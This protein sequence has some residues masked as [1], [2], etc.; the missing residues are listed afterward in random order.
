MGD[1]RSGFQAVGILLLLAG[2]TAWLLWADPGPA[3]GLRHAYLIP[4]LWGGLRFGRRGGALVSV[5]AVLLYAPLVLPALEEQGVGRETLE[6]LV[7]LGW[8]GGIGPLAGGLVSR[9]RVRAERYDT[10]LT[11]QR[12]LAS[13]GP[14]DRLLGEVAEQARRSLR[15]HAVTLAVAG[16]GADPVVVRSE[17]AEAPRTTTPALSND[18][19]AAW[20][21]SRGRTLFIP[22]LGSDPRLAGDGLA[23]GRPRRALLVPLQGQAA[24]M[25]VMVV[26]RIG[27]LR[28]GERAALETLGL[29]LAL[30]IQN[31]RLAERQRRFAEELEEKVARATRRLRE[32]DRA[33]SDFVSMVSHELR[34]PLTSIQGFSELLLN[35]PV[36]PE[37]QRRFVGYILQESERLGRIV[38]DLLD[39]S[40]IE[41]GT[42]RPLNRIPL[43]LVPLL[44]VNAEL[45]SCQSPVHEVRVEVSGDLPAVLADRDAVDRVLK[46][47]LSNAIKYSPRGGP[48]LLRAARFRDDPGL[49]EISVEDRGVGI[50]PEAMER[51]FEK[52][53]R[54]L[55]PDAAKVR[56]LGIGLALVKSLVEAQG[57]S[58]SV[59]SCPG[60]GSCFALTLPVA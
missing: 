35:R 7:F 26:E 38:E 9:A 37:R 23:P 45:F 52:Y 32:L 48:V 30:G 49:V 10:L 28:S 47:L 46:N 22:D 55:H 60:H 56:G 11:L 12:T 3:P 6:G 25:G 40:R 59:T 57:G 34:T 53:Y 20:A 41:A 33:K 14:L 17:E 21:W 5:L 2:I 1:D 31:S 16:D 58:V 51:V 54:I 8:L 27:E 43:D 4:A 29:Q 50:P 24:P 13:G 15:V 39:L 19:A 44:E 36:P 18:S 42:G